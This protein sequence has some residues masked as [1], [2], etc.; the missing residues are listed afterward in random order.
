MTDR[1]WRG[2]AE[3]IAHGCQNT[4][5]PILRREDLFT[6]TINGKGIS[7]TAT[8]ALVST[9]VDG[10]VA[11]WNSSTIPEASEVTAA[12]MDSDEDG[13]SDYLELTADTAGVP[14][15]IS[16]STSDA[17]GFSVNLTVV[18]SGSADVNE[19]QR[20]SLPSGTSG[21]THTLTFDGQ[22]TA[23]IAYDASAAA[24]ESA[25]EGLSN[26]AAGDVSVTGDA[27]G[28]WTVE[29]LQ[30]Y[31]GVNVPLITGDGSSLT[32]LASVKV[33]TTQ[34]GS[35]AVSELQQVVYNHNSGLSAEVH[36]T[37]PITSQTVTFWVNYSGSLSSWQ[38]A[39]D[40]AM[41]DLG[42]GGTATLT[43]VTPGTRRIE[44]R[45]AWLGRNVEQIDFLTGGT[46][47]LGDQITTIRNGGGGQNETQTV[48]ILGGP[49]GGTFT[50]TFSGQTTA[51]IAYDAAASAV[52]TALEGLASFSSGDVV[53]SGDAGGPWLVEFQASY[54]K[55]DMDLFSGDGSSL[56]GGGTQTLSL[57]T[58]ARS[59]GP[60]HFDD[61]D[62]WTGFRVP[63][64]LD[65]I[66][67]EG[68]SVDCLYGTKMAAAFTADDSTDTLT[69]D[70]GAGADFVLDQIVRVMSTGTLPAG[71]S[72]GTDYYVIAIDYDAG[73]MQLS[74]SSGG[75]AVDITDAGSGTHYVALKLTALHLHSRWA[76]AN[77]GLTEINEN[78]YYEYRNRSLA[79]AADTI[80][81]GAGDGDGSPRM[82]I[83][84]GPWQ[85][86]ITLLSTGGSQESGLTAFRWKGTH[87]SNVVTLVDGEFGASVYAT[88]SSVISAFTQRAGFAMIENCTLG[89]IDKTG[90]ELLADA[91]TLAG[92]V[93]I[94]G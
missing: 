27:G 18:Q 2:D 73:T 52:Q 87:A 40:A 61:P 94:R 58:T 60:N 68:G 85:T 16:A 11:A 26:I 84:T 90:G 81:V 76:N 14:F 50:L 43:E 75:G 9:V 79:L 71:L 39:F 45:A 83:D 33:T 67:Y 78:E 15:E 38:L 20:I 21:G 49:T 89:S 93:N 28:P 48:A 80:L 91:A 54:A 88:E 62:N 53:V 22:T 3:A 24:V 8:D 59:K 1:I 72:T 36:L 74:A 82:D 46:T 31:A 86:A 10:L 51:A 30:A 47:S 7:F 13:L 4:R 37:D 34:E 92:A 77:L 69:L 55:T 70:G 64:S 63:D 23:A 44:F 56:T 32:G 17:G 41:A 57:L 66:Y 12:A 6:L 35:T 25:L 19:K 29:F 5:P 42:S 65:S